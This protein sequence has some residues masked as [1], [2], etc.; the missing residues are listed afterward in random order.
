VDLLFCFLGALA[1]GVLGSISKV[2]EQRHY[3]AS[4]LVVSMGGLGTLAML[5]RTLTLPSGFSVPL[6]VFPVAVA[7]GVCAAVAYFAFQTSIKMGKVTVGW[8][9]MNLSAGVPA[10]VSIWAYDEKLTPIKIIALALGVVS[11]VCVFRGQRIE[12]QRAGKAHPEKECA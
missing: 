10:V 3:S 6:K 8:L 12:A 9:I 11:V 4:G 5:V 7:C 2:A 1:F